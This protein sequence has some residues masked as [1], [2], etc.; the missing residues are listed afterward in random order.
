[1]VHGIGV[2]DH[3]KVLG[4]HQQCYLLKTHLTPILLVGPT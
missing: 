2:P 1:M 3:S 4:G